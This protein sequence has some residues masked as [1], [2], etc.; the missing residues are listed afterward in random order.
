MASEIIIENLSRHFNYTILLN[1]SNSGEVFPLKTH[2][3]TVSLASCGDTLFSSLPLAFL[4]YKLIFVAFLIFLLV[5][6]NLRGVK[7]SVTVLADLTFSN[8]PMGGWIA[9]ITILSGGKDTL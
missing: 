8:W 4:K 2:S 9:L 5:V 3:I 1:G 7:E 6:M